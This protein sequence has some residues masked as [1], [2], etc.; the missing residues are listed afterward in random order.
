M[1]CGAFTPISLPLSC[2]SEVMWE[3]GMVKIVCAPCCMT[4][5]SDITS[6]GS[7]LAAA[8]M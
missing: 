7:P 1:F 2:E 8:S 4:E 5:P 6:S 3:L